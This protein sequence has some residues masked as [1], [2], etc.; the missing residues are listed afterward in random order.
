M[1]EYTKLGDSFVKPPAR[2][3]PRFFTSDGERAK[4]IADGVYQLQ[5]GLVVRE[6]AQP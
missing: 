1:V 2:S 5:S 3:K 6:S 4:Q